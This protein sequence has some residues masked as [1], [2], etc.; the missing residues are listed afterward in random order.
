MGSRHI[1]RKL[2][3]QALYQA[4]TRPDNVEDFIDLFFH[5]SNYNDESKTWAKQL[6]VNTWRHKDQVDL[7]IKQYAIGWTLDR[8]SRIDLSVLRLAFYE[9]LESDTPV[10]VVLNEA[11]ELVKE[12]S[13]DES[14]KFINGILGRYVK[15]HVHRSSS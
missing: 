13:S 11:I 12:F 4:S 10:N 6:V 14:S 1:S 2:A 3:M 9:L 7:L 5:E 15:E 8:I